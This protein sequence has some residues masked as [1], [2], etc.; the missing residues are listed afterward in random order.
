MKI[1]FFG[2]IVGKPGRKAIKKILPDLKE[3]H[4]PDFIIA[5][6]ENL[7]HGKG[8]NEKTIKE[9][10]EAGIDAFTSG[11]HIFQRK[12][13][14]PL[15]EK[16]DTNIIRPAN[17]PPQAPGAGFKFF[18]IR[19]KKLLLINLIG[20]VFFREDYDCPFRTIDN[21]L[22]KAQAEKPNAIIVDIHT[23]ATSESKALG[24][25]L[26]G[27][28]SAVFGTHTHVPTADAEILG[29]YTAYVTDVGMVGVKDSVLGVEK[30][31][32]IEQFLTQLPFKFDILERGICEVNSILVEID[33][34]GKAKKIEK[35]YQEVK[36]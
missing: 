33:E 27:R 9:M 30:E 25:Y 2:D 16:R 29:K 18:S 22:E 12:E 34:K 28:V 23:E 20:R 19:T 32:V 24:F 6:A 15:L 17:Y 13:G 36:V 7:A 21:I 11:N 14:L 31:S 1:L 35:I 26:D 8:I 3:K 5:N 4:S 10:T